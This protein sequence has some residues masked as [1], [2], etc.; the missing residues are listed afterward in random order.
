MMPVTHPT[1][2]GG[3]RPYNSARRRAAAA[4]HRRAVLDA[5]RDLLL[6]DGYRATTIRGVAERAGVSPDT[7]YKTFGSKPELM[8]A[9]YDV[10]VAGDDEPVP[11][12]Q[13]PPIQRALQPA[14]PAEKVNRY[15]EFV[16]GFMQR[17]GG[18]VAVLAEADP[19]I[20]EVRTVTEAERL[21]GVR[22]FVGHLA[23]E[24]HLNSGLGQQQAADACWALTSPQLYA[25]LTQ[26]R[27]W[28]AQAY[29]GWLT[30]MLRAT[31][32]GH[33]HGSPGSGR[34]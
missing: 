4:S 3:R 31:L 7:I 23:G 33:E 34:P 15:A 16:A 9:V 20:A 26:A 30:D 24:G 19:E 11:I 28:T 32:L 2:A 8:K 29:Q 6:R 1:D 22:A 25:Q 13:R 12:G 18:M 17:L 14:D 5:S 21:T 27:G 10:T